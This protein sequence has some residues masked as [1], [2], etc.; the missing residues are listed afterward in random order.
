MPHGFAA[1]N[2]VRLLADGLSRAGAQ[3]KVLIPW[4]TER[5]EHPLNTCFKGSLCG[6]TYEYTTGDPIR[7]KELCKR[8]REVLRAHTHTCLRLKALKKQNRLDA[9]IYYGGHLENHIIYRSLSRLLKVPYISFLVEWYPA[10]PRQNISRR[11]YDRAFNYL[12]MTMTDAVVV[13]SRYLELKV[14]EPRAIPFSPPRCYRMP[15]LVNPRLWENVKPHQSHRPYVLFCAD[16]EGYYRD[17]C[18]AIRSMAKL[19]R[20]DME[21]MLIGSASDETRNCLQDFAERSGLRSRLIIYDHFVPG[22]TLRELFAGSQALLAPLHDDIRSKARFPS[23]IADYLMAA[24]PVVSCNV[25]EVAEFLHNRVTAYLSQPDDIDDFVKSLRLAL[26]DEAREQVAENGKSLALKNF[27]YRLQGK[28]LFDFITSLQ[29][30]ET[31]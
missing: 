24:R 13:I 17:A 20:Q 28:R 9:V 18:F 11:L 6:F 22:D 15:I 8:V 1:S 29:R 3:I 10:I 27:D 31:A 23:K 5:P 14:K 2:Y 30:K 4:H 26:T 25:G 19:G 16:L 12:T 7:P 21:L